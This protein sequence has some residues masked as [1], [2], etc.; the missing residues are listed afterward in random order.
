MVNNY[1]GIELFFK[2][3]HSNFFNII[4]NLIK[5]NLIHFSVGFNWI[6]IYKKTCHF[7]CS[8]LIKSWR[9]KQC[10]MKIKKND[11]YT[12]LRRLSRNWKN[13]WKKSD[14]FSVIWRFE[15]IFETVFTSKKLTNGLKWKFNNRKQMIKASNL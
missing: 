1:C 7:K 11:G 4:F 2:W 3:A 9:Q 14:C 6:V 8:Y 15:T 5:L 10:V 13:V 12:N